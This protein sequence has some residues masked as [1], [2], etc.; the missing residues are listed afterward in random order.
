MLFICVT[1]VSVAVYCIIAHV[2][3]SFEMNIY[4]PATATSR[5]EVEEAYNW[6]SLAGPE[7]TNGFYAFLEFFMR[8]PIY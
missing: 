7:A 6:G 8:L 5:T 1:V 2:N 4:D 3:G